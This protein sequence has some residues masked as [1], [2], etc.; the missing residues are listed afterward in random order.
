MKT[1]GW[2]DY[3]EG[4]TG[5]VDLAPCDQDGVLDGFG[6]D[7]DAVEGSVSVV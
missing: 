5:N 7:I 2:C 3:P 4:A 6:W 1:T